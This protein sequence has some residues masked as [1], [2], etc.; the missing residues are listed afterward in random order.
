MNGWM[1]GWVDGWTGEWMDGW[2]NGWMNGWMGRWVDGW[3]GEWMGGWK[4]WVRKFWVLT[5]SHK[6]R[7]SVHFDHVPDTC[8]ALSPVSHYLAQSS[9]Q[10]Y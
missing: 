6:G 7:T 5:A 2:I 9:L 1:N 8:Q 3:V 10:L 4:F